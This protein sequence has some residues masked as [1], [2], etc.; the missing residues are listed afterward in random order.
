MY[1]KLYAILF[2]SLVDFSGT[3]WNC[4]RRDVAMLLD[5]NKYANRMNAVGS[6]DASLKCI[7]RE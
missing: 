3:K 2:K 5:D 4:V 1:H 6:V 7:W